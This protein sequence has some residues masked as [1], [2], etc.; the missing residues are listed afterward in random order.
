MTPCQV[1]DLTERRL[2]IVYDGRELFRCA[3]CGLVYLD[4]M[5]T[6][7]EIAALYTDA[8]GGASDGYFR[9]VPAKMRRSRR[10][11]P[12]PRPAR[13]DLSGPRPAPSRCRR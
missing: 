2:F 4:P 13:P 11:V 7:E 12:R 3:V 8:Y 5:P 9:K 1:C 6:A 10:R